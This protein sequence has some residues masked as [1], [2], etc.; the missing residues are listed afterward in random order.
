MVVAVPPCFRG[1][2]I[3]TLQN[4]PETSQ[5]VRIGKVQSRGLAAVVVTRGAGKQIPL[6]EPL[7][8][9]LPRIC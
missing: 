1:H 6:D 2:A 8:A 3:T 4:V 7:G 9:P 5:A